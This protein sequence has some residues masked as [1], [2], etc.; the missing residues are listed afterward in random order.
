MNTSS[1]DL[2]NSGGT[3]AAGYSEGPDSA[4]SA[5]RTSQDAPGPPPT[6]DPEAHQVVQDAPDPEE[7]PD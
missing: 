1:T 2:S 5:P 7:A 4:P 6:D 3:A